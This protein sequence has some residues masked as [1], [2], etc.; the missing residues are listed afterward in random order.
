MPA[1]DAVAATMC[2]RDPCAV[3]GGCQRSSGCS[4]IL[5]RSMEKGHRFRC[6]KV[7]LPVASAGSYWTRLG[8]GGREA[9]AQRGL[10]S[11]P[12]EFRTDSVS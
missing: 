12:P 9:G 3:P 11:Q 1:W 2:T 4:Y 7:A 5:P 8:H 10:R 6:R